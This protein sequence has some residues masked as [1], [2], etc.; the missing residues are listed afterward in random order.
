MGGHT[1][2]R[3]GEAHNQALS[4]RPAA[5]VLAAVLAEAP[6]LE[7]RIKALGKGERELLSPGGQARDHQLNRRGEVH[8]VCVGA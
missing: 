7:G 8:M 3:G 4:E 6:A 5:G 2:R 1:D